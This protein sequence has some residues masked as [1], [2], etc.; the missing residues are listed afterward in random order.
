MAPILVHTAAAGWGNTRVSPCE[1]ES[2]TGGGGGCARAWEEHLLPT[3]RGGGGDNNFG[4]PT[5]SRLSARQFRR[6]VRLMLVGCG[7]SH[8]LQ[9]ENVGAAHLDWSLM[10]GFISKRFTFPVMH[11]ILIGESLDS[12]LMHHGL[13]R[14]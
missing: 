5:R 1:P 10:P 12:C 3:C 4:S 14:F 2:R 13:I 9:G 6:P 7:R 11:V 8:Q